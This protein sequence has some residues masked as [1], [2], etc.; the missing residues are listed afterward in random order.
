M[1]F[2]TNYDELSKLFSIPVIIAAFYAIDE[3]HG[4]DLN[5]I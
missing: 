2:M 1:T 4:K 3:T 5:F